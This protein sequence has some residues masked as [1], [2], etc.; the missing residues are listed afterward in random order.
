MAVK[1][2]IVAACLAAISYLLMFLSFVIVPIVP[3]M[4]LD[5]SD[6]PILLAFFILGPLGGIQV[7]FLRSLLYFLIAGPSLPQLIGV[8]LSF[9]ATLAFCL[10]L[11]YLLKNKSLIWQNVVGA[12]LGATLSL[13][14]VLAVLNWLVT[15]PLYMSLLGMKLSIPLGQMILFGVVPFN[16]IKGIVVGTAFILIYKKLSVWIEHKK[17]LHS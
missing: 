13:T 15:I 17:Y 7:A 8:S 5:F 10:P 4:K 9:V 16:L 1:R 11:Y 12:I 14:V 2:W 3:F 6:I